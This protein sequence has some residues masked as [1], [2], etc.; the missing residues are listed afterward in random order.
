M[1]IY[2][3][4]QELW[5]MTFSLTKKAGEEINDVILSVSRVA[6]STDANYDFYVVIAHDMR[7]PEIQI[8]I[9]KSVDD[10]K[11]FML[12]DISRGEFSKRML[13]DKRINPQA[14]KEHAIKEVFEK[15]GLDKKWQDAVMDDF[16]RSQPAAL[17]DI[18]YWNDR[19]YVK[20]IAL[21]EFLAEQIAGRIR[22][23]FFE[24]KAMADK[25]VIK[26]SKGSYLP[27]GSKRYF[28]IEVLAE[29]R[30]F[31]QSNEEAKN[32]V[33]KKSL[34]ICARVL[35]GYRYDHYNYVEI[36]DET[37]GK[38]LKASREELEKFRKK[39]MTFDNILSQAE[40]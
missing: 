20:D 17:G 35:H 9:I 10:V 21:P 13:I 24:D 32:S 1:A 14:K 30:S 18:G 25:A 31:S 33:F 27:D 37:S 2:L 34:E 12:N 22:M 8:I 40:N 19:F 6:L 26:S 4:L 11:R 28:Q 36:V 3:P 7:I 16:F 29:P 15:M 5:D 23:D 38:S 39:Q